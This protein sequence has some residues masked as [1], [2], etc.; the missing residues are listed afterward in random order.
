MKKQAMLIGCAFVTGMMVGIHRRVI[1]ACI[2][3][4]P[5]PQAPASHFWLKN[6]KSA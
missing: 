1:K 4:E 6:R 2:A 5:L 3:G